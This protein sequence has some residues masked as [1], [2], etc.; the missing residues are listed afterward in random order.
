MNED[1]QQRFLEK[2]ERE[3]ECLV[4]TAH[5]D[6]D[7]YGTFHLGG[8]KVFAHRVA[9]YAKTGREPPVVRHTCD[10]P[11]CVNPS[12]LRGG[13]QLDNVR[14]RDRKDRQAKGSR[15]GRA[16]LSAEDVRAIR[17]RYRKEESASYAS[18]ADEYD[19]GRTTVRDII[20]RETW[21]HIGPQTPKS[22]PAGAE[23]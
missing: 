15:N 3:G 7:G 21:S 5:R 20:K 2:V 14:D 8:R 16:R 19:V 18:L 6:P 1:A 9:F 13:T 22:A 10:N 4:W 12:H 23:G 17:R 11:A